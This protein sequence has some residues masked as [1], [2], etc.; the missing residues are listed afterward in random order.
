MQVEWLILA[1]A[2]QVVGGKLYLLG[3]G[4]DTLAVHTGFPVQQHLAL[5]V[6]LR[7]P[8]HET[9]ERHSVSVAVESEDGQV[10]ATASAEFEVGRPPGIPRGQDQ[11][12]QFAMSVPLTL[13]RPGTYVAVA[14]G[15]ALEE[16]R[17]PFNVVPRP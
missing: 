8:W 11:R 13:E 14:R 10:L 9:N 4:W 15:P 12:V 6:A 2:A 16:R 17:V 3:G 1:D 5:A 7:V